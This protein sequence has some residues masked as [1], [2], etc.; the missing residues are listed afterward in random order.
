ML[1]AE[2]E[3]RVVIHDKQRVVGRISQTTRMRESG[4]AVD[5][6]AWRGVAGDSEVAA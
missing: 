2:L 4:G 6:A 1:D 5:R 3:Q